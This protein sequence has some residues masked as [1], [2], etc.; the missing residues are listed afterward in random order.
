MINTEEKNRIR[1]IIDEFKTLS[2]GSRLTVPIKKAPRARKEPEPIVLGPSA[3]MVTWAL[4]K[5]E[6]EL[7]AVQSNHA[8]CHSTAQADR[9]LI[10]SLEKKARIV[11]EGMVLIY[12]HSEGL[13]KA[14]AEQVLTAAGID[15][16]KIK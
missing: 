16:T 13:V 8:Y 3:A 11:G 7:Q 6:S 9:E 14:Y 15:V 4:E 2:S 10:T 12:Q 5:L 1:A